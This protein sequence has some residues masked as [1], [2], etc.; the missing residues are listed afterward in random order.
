MNLKW[1]TGLAVLTVVV[2]G[3]LL[4]IPG[5]DRNA[6][7]FEQGALLPKLAE[8]VNALDWVQVISAGDQVVATLERG[9]QG[10]TVKEAN[11]Y[12]ADWERLR[13]VLAGLAQA[14]VLEPKTANAAYYDRLGV[15]DI[16]DEDAQGVLVR[17]GE[18]SGVA[19]VIIGNAA[20]GRSGQYA[21]LADS[22]DSVLLDREIDLPGVLEDWL[23]RGIIDIADSELVE[24]E[25]RHPDG[26]T[27][28]ITKVSADDPDFSLQDIPDGREI[29]S[30]WAVNSLAG[31]LNSLEL[32]DVMPRPESL[33][34][35]AVAYRALGAD[36]LVVEAHWF[37]QNAEDESQSWLVIEASAGDEATE[38]IV[39]RAALINQR[40]SGWAY[41]VPDYKFDSAT[42]RL[43]DV[44]KD[45]DATA[46]GDGEGS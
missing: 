3:L 39:E 27:L 38:A 42:K 13:G 45:V 35:S 17:F 24:V 44:L 21:R 26:E 43:E 12:A 6:T 41:R 30:N 33:P 37:E 15:E 18:D 25:I 9:D 36:G 10:W 4:L 46:A 5:D 20:Q 32:D 29:Q 19:A 14:R 40:A 31:A 22:A 34:D 11:G 8:Q 28:R 2:A 1:L 7:N 16:G 23:D